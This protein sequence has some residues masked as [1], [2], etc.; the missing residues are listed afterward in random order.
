M[1][2]VTLRNVSQGPVRARLIPGMILKPAE[3]QPVQPLLIVEEEKLV[4]QPGEVR[5][6]RLRAF[7]MDSRVP[8]PISGQPVDYR[9]TDR[10]RDGGP[11]AVRTYRAAEKLL[12]S[13]PYRHAI[14]QIAIWKALGQPVEEEHYLSVLG[15]GAR[16]PVVLKE[17][18]R[19]VDR[20]LRAAKS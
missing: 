5:A 16:N 2:Y 19:Q 18:L 3:E 15:P 11:E 13:S 17:V 12:K 1:V 8:A 14:T 4:L 20:V 10:T 6:L 9:F 7:C